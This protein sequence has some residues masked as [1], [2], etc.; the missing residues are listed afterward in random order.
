LNTFESE[1]TDTGK[2]TPL[3][4]TA[5]T[6]KVDAAVDVAP[7]LSTEFH[8]NPLSTTN[9]PRRETLA[10]WLVDSEWR[11]VPPMIDDNAEL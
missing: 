8:L 6:E 10:I 5:A 9:P 4:S 11:V 3:T 2:V 1:S 7:V